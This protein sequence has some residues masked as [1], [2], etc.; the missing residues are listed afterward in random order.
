MPG[1]GFIRLIRFLNRKVCCG[2]G[3]GHC[4][5][6]VAGSPGSGLLIVSTWTVTSRGGFKGS[7]GLI[8]QVH[9]SWGTMKILPKIIWPM[10]KVVLIRCRKT[11]VELTSVMFPKKK[12]GKKM[13]R[14][15]KIRCVLVHSKIRKVLQK[16]L[17][18][19]P[20][21]PDFRPFSLFFFGGGWFLI[22]PE[23]VGVSCW[24]TRL[25]H[26]LFLLFFFLKRLEP[27]WWGRLVMV[28]R[29]SRMLEK[30]RNSRLSR[31]CCGLSAGW[32]VRFVI[33][34]DNAS[35][36]CSV[37]LS[38][39][40]VFQMIC[41]FVKLDMC[42]WCRRIVLSLVFLNLV[43]FFFFW[44]CVCCSNWVCCSVPMSCEIG[45]IWCLWHVGCHSVGNS[46]YLRRIFWLV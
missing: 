3:I 40:W 41:L 38:L 33:V 46:S 34:F 29:L 13:L 4:A 12:E 31:L 36:L 11:E 42:V 26:S 7:L 1:I 30:R 20:Q 17:F 10:S 21:L 35:P 6:G 27:F 32:V 22:D 24:C 45:A 19:D 5:W 14:E 2:S 16:F 28:C 43:F 18:L 37:F 23:G 8:N 39:N 15:R 44:S 25:P 9:R